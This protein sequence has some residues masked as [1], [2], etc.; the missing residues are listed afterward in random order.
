M[1][2][3][4]IVKSISI[5]LRRYIRTKVTISVKK[6]FPQSAKTVKEDGEKCLLI[7]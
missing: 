1:V 2:A 5:F 7:S 4:K 3:G 6:G